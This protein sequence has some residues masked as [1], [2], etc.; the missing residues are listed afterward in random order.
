MN[1]GSINGYDVTYNKESDT[2]FCKDLQIPAEK[3][4][5][6]Y[7][8]SLDRCHIEGKLVMRKFDGEITLGCLKLSNESGKQLI[9]KIKN[10]RINENGRLRATD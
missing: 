2:L 4:I 10:E 7:E 6:A 5:R 1:I 3:L 8:S 9:R